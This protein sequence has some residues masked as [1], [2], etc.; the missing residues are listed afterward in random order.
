MKRINYIFLPVI[1]SIFFLS[2]DDILEVHSDR[3]VLIDDNAMKSDSLYAMF[4]IL[5]EL[6]KIAD[7]YVI[8][9]EL[10][11]ELLETSESA[12][13]YL[14]EISQFETYSPENPYTSNKADYYSIINNCNYVLH[15]VDTAKVYKG[16]KPLYKVMAAA[17]AV[18]AWTYMQLVLN[19]GEACYF[20]QPIL[21]IQEALKENTPLRM[22]ALFPQLITE[23]LPYK[24]I[25]R[26]NPGEFGGFQRSSVLYFPV[27]FVLGDLYLWMGQYQ[28]AATTY[29]EL[30]YRNSYLIRAQYANRREVIGIGANMEFTTNY[31][32]NWGALFT[33]KNAPEYITA[34]AVSNKDSYLTAIE[35]LFYPELSEISGL[36]DVATL[37]PTQ[38]AINKFDSTLYFHDYKNNLGTTALTTYGDLRMENA[39][40]RIGIGDNFDNHYCKVEKYHLM[41]RPE[42]ADDEDNLKEEANIV[43]PYRVALLYLRYA[44]AVNRLGKPNTAMAVLKNGLNRQAFLNPQVIPA[45]EIGSSLPEYMNFT[46][47]RFDANIGIHARGAGY[48]ARDSSFYIINMKGISQP[49]QQDS[50][51]FV[52][53]LIQKELVL[54]M[55][56]EGTRFQD[57]MRFAIYRNDN[58]YLANIVAEKYRDAGTKERV[59]N[60]LISRENWYLK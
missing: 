19:F 10:R 51:L 35:T 5:S 60:K 30:I 6:Q 16:E 23:L 41:N 28:E 33:G 12:D 54:E 2:C 11:G 56:Y 55:A 27:S 52:D 18:K 40:L 3:A 57:L 50:I 24:D 21:S 29:H 36:L 13:K 4:G 44:E 43:V 59:R 22:E 15:N 7:S 46:D 47:E 1:L 31:T 9:G 25:D 49:T 14:K 58:A 32:I 34:I 26:L 53:D 42:S 38:L 45:S 39:I 37:I 17:A 20:D 8:L 48:T